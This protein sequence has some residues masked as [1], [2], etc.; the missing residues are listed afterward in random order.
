MAPLMDTTCKWDPLCE[1]WYLDSNCSNHMTRH[2]EWPS[3]LDSSNKTNVRHVEYSKN[4]AVEGTCDNFIKRKD[5]KTTLLK[6]VQYM[7]G[8]K[9]NFMSIGQLVEKGFLV[10]ING[11]YLQFF[12]S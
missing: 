2:N 3:N 12:S 7:L 11:N 5:G 8:M 4:L 1:D 6:N 10:T 9:C